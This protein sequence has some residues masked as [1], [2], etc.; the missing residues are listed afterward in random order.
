MTQEIVKN[1][2]ILEADK[3]ALINGGGWPAWIWKALTIVATN[4]GDIKEG[5]VDG[6]NDYKK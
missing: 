5:F 6:W 3:L 4:F 1:R 2:V